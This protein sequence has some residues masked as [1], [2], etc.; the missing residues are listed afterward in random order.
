MLTSFPHFQPTVKHSFRAQE[1]AAKKESRGCHGVDVKFKFGFFS[2]CANQYQSTCALQLRIRRDLNCK[3]KNM[4]NTNDDT[5]PEQSS[6]NEQANNRTSQKSSCNRNYCCF[7]F[8][9]ISFISRL[10]WSKD[11]IF[12]YHI[13]FFGLLIGHLD[14]HEVSPCQ[15]SSC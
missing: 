2:N 11:E 14:G 15:A 12:D 4:N 7:C 10:S 3:Q 8:Q 1:R 5:Q 9:Q 6:T 13:M